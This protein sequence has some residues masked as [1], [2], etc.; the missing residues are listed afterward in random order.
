VVSRR[1]FLDGLDVRGTPILQH[2]VARADRVTPSVKPLSICVCLAVLQVFTAN[3][4]ILG[5]AGHSDAWQTFHPLFLAIAQSAGLTAE[6]SAKFI[7]VMTLTIDAIAA[8]HLGRP[9]S[10]SPKHTMSDCDGALYKAIAQAF[11]N[12]EQGVAAGEWG[13]GACVC[14]G[15][16]V[17]VRDLQVPI[18]TKSATSTSCTA[19]GRRRSTCESRTC[20][21]MS[22]CGFD[23]FTT[24]PLKT[25]SMRSTRCSS[26]G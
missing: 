14:V 17:C 21:T 20:T 16:S 10:F 12:G 24:A 8:E 26:T 23:R 9:F 4:H 18:C 2:Y 3:E 22:N 7:E 11:W 6:L 13:D 19:S 25:S 1:Q 15:V 5:I